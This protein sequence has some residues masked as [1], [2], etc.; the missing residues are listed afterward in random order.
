[1]GGTQERWLERSCAWCLVEGGGPG[2]GLGG[3]EGEND[4]LSFASGGTETGRGLLQSL[5][6]SCARNTPTR[7]P[8]DV[9]YCFNHLFAGAS[10]VALVVKNLPAK[11]GDLRD[12]GPSWVCKIS[13]GR[14]WQPT[15]VFLPGESMD[16]GAWWA[17]VHGVKRVRQ[18]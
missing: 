13:W 2:N 17:T 3:R 12:A 5:P 8:G 10:Q 16:R 14:A 15:P 7:Q 6:C 9:L 18:D 4:C 11:A 1:M